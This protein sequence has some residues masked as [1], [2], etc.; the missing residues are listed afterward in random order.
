MSLRKKPYPGMNFEHFMWMFTRLS[1]LIIFT[2]ALVG[3]IG[4]LIMGARTQMDL[5]TLMRWTFFPTHFHVDGS[6]IDIDAGWLSNI[7]LWF[8]YAIIF[9]GVTHGLNGLRM[10]IEDYWQNKTVQLILRVLMF[11]SWAGLIYVA[12]ILVTKY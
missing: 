1:G 11:A 2:I 10:V 3:M 6:D 7:W 9:F 5:G 8:Q 4:A 12:V